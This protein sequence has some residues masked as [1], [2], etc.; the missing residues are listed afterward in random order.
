VRIMR[1]EGNLQTDGEWHRALLH[2]LSN[3]DLPVADKR[4]LIEAGKV[5]KSRPRGF[6][7]G[8][9]QREKAYLLRHLA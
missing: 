3:L 8:L 9:N 7:V 4:R 1:P 2:A 5:L 6:R